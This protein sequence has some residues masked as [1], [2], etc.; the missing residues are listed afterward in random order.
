MPRV[1]LN[2]CWL[3]T[4]EFR[5][6][7]NKNPNRARYFRGIVSN[8]DQSEGRKHCFLA[9]DWLKFVTLPRKYRTLY[10][11]Y[12]PQEK[13]N[14]KGY[15][16]NLS[17]DRT[18]NASGPNQKSGSFISPTSFPGPSRTSGRTLFS[19]TSPRDSTIWVQHPCSPTQT[20][21]LLLVAMILD[22]EQRWLK[23]VPYLL[24]YSHRY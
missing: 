17:M 1:K 18:E 15:M 23:P 7:K 22:L 13:I 11:I 5:S 10:N 8:F 2:D 20:R 9:F 3:K 12:S 4:S 24:I 6:K 16:G 21:L 19:S 14:E